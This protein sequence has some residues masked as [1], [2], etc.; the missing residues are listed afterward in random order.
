MFNSL[1]DI[2]YSLMVV[3]SV[4][5]VIYDWMICLNCLLIKHEVFF[6]V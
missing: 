3:L 2:K 6:N 1:V 4:V 5:I